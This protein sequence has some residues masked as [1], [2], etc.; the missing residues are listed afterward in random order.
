MKLLKYNA[1]TDRVID[2][3]SGEIITKAVE[4]EDSIKKNLAEKYGQCKIL[5]NWPQLAIMLQFLGD[6]KDKTVLDL[7]CGSATSPD[8]ELGCPNSKKYRSFEPW[9]LRKVHMLGAK[10]IGIDLGDLSKEE[11][12][13][14]QRDL[15]NPNTFVDFDSN[16]IDFAHASML[17]D[18]PSV[19][20]NGDVLLE[21][22]LPHLERILKSEAVF[23]F[24]P[25]DTGLRREEDFKQ[26][27]QDYGYQE[28]R[29]A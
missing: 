18:S 12:T 7:G 8:Y 25:D 2:I 29:K 21:R 9:F 28:A 5:P 20:H 27:L 26:F 19:Q 4:M 3:V 14:Y 1:R 6:I 16:S 11:F 15:F 13:R 23:M 24:D 17:F 10:A 22:I